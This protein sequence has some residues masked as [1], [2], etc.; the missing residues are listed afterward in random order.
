[1]S[2]QTMNYS[3]YYKSLASMPE[4]IMVTQLPKAKIDINALV[5]YARSKGKR[6]SELNEAEQNQFIERY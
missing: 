5:Q 3:K 6:V 1:M 2:G 4:P